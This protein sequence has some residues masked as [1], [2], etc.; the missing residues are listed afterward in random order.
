MP[1]EPSRLDDISD[2]LYELVGAVKESS[3]STLRALGEVQRDVGHLR[4]CHEEERLR[5]V[6][7][8]ARVERLEDSIQRFSDAQAAHARGRSELWRALLQP[9]GAAVLMLASWLWGALH[10]LGKP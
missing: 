5:G 9:L 4:E 3:S 10:P 2:R 6:R 1:D 8:E 7:L